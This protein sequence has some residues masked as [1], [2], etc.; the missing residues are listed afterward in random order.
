MML[1]SKVFYPKEQAREY[2]PIVSCYAL[3]LELFGGG[4]VDGY[5]FCGE[6]YHRQENIT[7]LVK[8]WM[9]PYEGESVQ[10]AK[11]HERRKKNEK[12]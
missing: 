1:K 2:G 5:Y 3:K 4:I 12:T 10:C 7:R 9:I 8:R 11:S 6:F